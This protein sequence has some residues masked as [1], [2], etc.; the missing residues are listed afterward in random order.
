MF[1]DEDRSGSTSWLVEPLPTYGQGEAGMRLWAQKVRQGSE[2][3]E[4][5]ICCCCPAPKSCRTL[6]T[7][8][9]AAPGSPV[10]HYLLKFAQT[11]V[12]SVCDVIQ[13][14]LSPPSP[15]VLNLSQHQGL[16]QKLE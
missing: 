5:D 9:I 2:P 16:F 14:S 15:L 10:L 4:R 13:P 11:H 1:L 7:P 12:H 3:P 6:W 8:W